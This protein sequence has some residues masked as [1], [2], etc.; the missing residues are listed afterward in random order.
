MS[1]RHGVRADNGDIHYGISVG[2]AENLAIQTGWQ[3]LV[4]R[5]NGWEDAE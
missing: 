2:D 1:I 5:G 3:L 4:D